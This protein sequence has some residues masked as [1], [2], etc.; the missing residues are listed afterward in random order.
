MAKRLEM[1]PHHAGQPQA[2]GRFGGRDV[3]HTPGER[4]MNGM[5]APEGKGAHT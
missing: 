4:I 1:L 3:T 2:G 5:W